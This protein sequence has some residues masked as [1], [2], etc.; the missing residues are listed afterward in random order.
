MSGNGYERVLNKH[1]GILEGLRIAV[2]QQEELLEDAKI[3]RDAWKR[4]IA[5]QGTPVSP[6]TVGTPAED[7]DIRILESALTAKLHELRKQSEFVKT[8]E[9]NKPPSR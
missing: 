8:L 4:H 1:R 3:E 7:R 9:E 6:D 5:K 2:T